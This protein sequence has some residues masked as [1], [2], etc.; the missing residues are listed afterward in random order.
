MSGVNA[1][2]PIA[3]VDVH[4]EGGGA[5]AAAVLIPDWPSPEVVGARTVRLDEVPPYRPGQFFLRE[6]PP[7]L[8]VLDGA[9]PLS[10][11][12]VDGYVDL[13]P[14]GRPGLGRHV[15]DALGIPVVGVA[16]TA[17]R[18]ADHARPV[19]RGAAVKPLF[20]TAAGLSPEAAAAHVAQMSGSFRLPDALRLVDRLARTGGV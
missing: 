20:V 7:L 11:V 10:A 19:V 3:A 9:G 1:G 8:A 15:Y 12:V 4:Y 13:D 14:A 16:K 6:L 17:F 2:A 5:R 18:G